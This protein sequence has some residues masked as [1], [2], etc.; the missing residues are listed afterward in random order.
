MFGVPENGYE[1]GNGDDIDILEFI[2]RVLVNQ[3][4]RRQKVGDD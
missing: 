2:T 4:Q 1:R 3:R